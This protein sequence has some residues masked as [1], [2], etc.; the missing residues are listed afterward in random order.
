MHILT[1]MSGCAGIGALEGRGG[2]NGRWGEGVWNGCKVGRFGKGRKGE[3]LRGRS[4]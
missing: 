3:G 4:G 1:R 2:G